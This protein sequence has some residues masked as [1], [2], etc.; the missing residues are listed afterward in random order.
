MYILSVTD[1]CGIV[2]KKE[3]NVKVIDA[4]AVF[5]VKYIDHSTVQ[6]IDL[7][8]SSIAQW[9]WD[10]GTGSGESEL[11]NPIYTFPDTG[12]YFFSCDG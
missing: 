6:F 7:S 1:S 2:R 5:D 12:P 10:F 9:N 11:Q 4:H 3:I 8:Y